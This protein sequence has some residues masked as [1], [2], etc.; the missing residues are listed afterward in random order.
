MAAKLSTHVLDTVH[1]KPAA[2]VRIELWQIDNG[3]RT[4]IKTV[5]TNNDG[6]TDAPLL[7][8]TEMQVG[9]YELIFHVASYFSQKSPALLV[10]PPF[11]DQVPIRFNIFDATAAY[12][13]PLLA[14]PWAYST[15]RGS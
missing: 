6:R 1:G 13:V 14:S 11:L 5:Q 4:L 15:Y 3:K 10:S 8:E 12:H 7:S 9:C 2:G